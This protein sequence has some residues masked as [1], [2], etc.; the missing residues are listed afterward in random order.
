MEKRIFSDPTIPAFFEASKKPFK[1]IPE[2]SQNG[3]VVFIV[4]GEDIDKALSELYSN[5]SI[6]VLDY[7]KALKGLR[8]SIFALKSIRQLHGGV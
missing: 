7:I 8:S 1:I 4:E 5:V 3:Q 6:N 2:K